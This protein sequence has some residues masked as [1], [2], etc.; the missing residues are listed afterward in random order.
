MFA[1]IIKNSELDYVCGV[2]SSLPHISEK[3]VAFAGRSNV[4]KSSLIN[5]LLNRKK[6]ARTSSTPGKTVTINFYHVNSEFYFVDLPGY[7]Y[8]K[9]SK[10]DRA[11][12][13][14]MIENY[15]NGSQTLEAVFLVLDLRRV[16]NDDDR[17]MLE[18]IFKS[19]VRPFIIA[20]KSDKLKKSEINKN[21]ENMRNALK[22]KNDVPVYIFSSVT[23]NGRDEILDAVEKICS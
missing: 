6:L 8:A 3:E 1:L 19:G 11:K 18:W 23:K 13:G 14:S 20:T 15:L 7:G 21:I 16:P 2:T 12:W 10:E 17:M 4:G 5:G 22:I 9:A